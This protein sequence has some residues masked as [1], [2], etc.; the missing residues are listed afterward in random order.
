MYYNLFLEVICRTLLTIP[1]IWQ[2]ENLSCSLRTAVVDYRVYQEKSRWHLDP[3][4]PPT[5]VESIP[6]EG[7]SITAEQGTKAGTLAAL[8]FFGYYYLRSNGTLI[9]NFTDDTY[10]WEPTWG[11][12]VQEFMTWPEGETC[13]FTWGNV[14]DGI[15]NQMH[16]LMFYMAV[17][18]DNGTSQSMFWMYL[19]LSCNRGRKITFRMG[20]LHTHSN[21]PIKIPRLLFR[22]LPDGNLLDLLDIAIVGL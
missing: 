9:H 8:D 14:T 10:A 2:V 11:I 12:V 19:V 5:V 4:S 6:Q 7:D 22:T 17:A 1:R 13:S 21:V 16:D 18:A 3:T 20:P 15:L